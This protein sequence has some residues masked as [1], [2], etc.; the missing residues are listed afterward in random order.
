MLLSYGEMLRNCIVL[1]MRWR[2][3]LNHFS[4]HHYKAYIN[5]SN[6]IW[7]WIGSDTHRWC[8]YLQFWPISIRKWRRTRSPWMTQVRPW[9]SNSPFSWHTLLSVGIPSQ[10]LLFWVGIESDSRLMTNSLVPQLLVAIHL[11]IFSVSGSV[12]GTSGSKAMVL[13]V[14]IIHQVF[15]RKIMK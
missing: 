9:F 13:V 2:V 14:V 15:F 5:H 6:P 7:Y 1:I 12:R 11:S 10:C 4:A 3:I 8:V